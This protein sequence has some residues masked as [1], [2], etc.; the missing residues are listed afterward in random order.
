[1]INRLVAISV[2]V[3]SA[4]VF[5]FAPSAVFGSEDTPKN[6]D[7]GSMDQFPVDN[8]GEVVF[9]VTATPEMLPADNKTESEIVVIL[10]DREGAPLEGREVTFYLEQGYGRLSPAFP[11]TGDDGIAEAVYMAGRIA[12]TA[13]IRITDVETGE[14]T[15]FE[16]PTSISASISLELVD[17]SRFISSFIKRQTATQLYTMSVDVFPDRLVADSF[18][19]SRITVN[20]LSLENGMPAVGVPLE[21]RLVSGDGEIIKD[22]NTTD[23]NGTLEVF[24]RSGDTPGTVIIEVIEPVT[25]LSETIEIAVLEEGPAKIKLFF[26]DADGNLFDE[27]AKLP[28]NGIETIVVVAQVLNLVDMPVPDVT[29]Q[30]SLSEEL[31]VI[32]VLESKSDPNGYV[33][34][35]FKAGMQTGI[36]TI[37]AFLTSKPI[38]NIFE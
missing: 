19:T 28:A 2:I 22:R 17:P 36:E 24:Y 9:E 12:A 33:Y 6:I 5:S 35:T 37:T 4:S 13:V 23:T 16:I 10:K 25:G 7:V 20:L 34:A 38:E 26:A 32:E 30:F 3:V 21:I 31:G 8:P 1:M 29:V 14:Y 27:A 11:V 15:F 18:S